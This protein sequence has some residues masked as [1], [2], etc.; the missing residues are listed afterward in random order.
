MKQMAWLLIGLLL[1]VSVGCTRPDWVSDVLTDVTGT[2]AA[3]F[4]DRQ[5][6]TRIRFHMTLAQSGARV[7][8]ETSAPRAS[9]GARSL[10]EGALE[11]AVNGEV[12]T[13]TIGRSGVR[14][15]VHLDGEEMIGS[16]EG[17]QAWPMMSCPC[18][19]HLLVKGQGRQASTHD[20]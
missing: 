4:T 19:I 2:W 12:F 16:L 10:I 6:T 1:L 13:F 18:P 17:P 11:G 8:G 7:T 9:P 15:Q 5:S 20:A 3:T 14:G